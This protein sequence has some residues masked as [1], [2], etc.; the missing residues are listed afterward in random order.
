MYLKNEYITP[1]EVDNYFPIVEEYDVLIGYVDA[2]HTT[3]I[4]TRRSIT[5]LRVNFCGAPISNR[6]KIKPTV[7]TT[8]TETEF[9]M[10]VNI[11]KTIEFL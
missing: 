3:Y 11:A 9:I 7:A 8:F 1:K 4:K 2:A 5:S 10:V 6:T